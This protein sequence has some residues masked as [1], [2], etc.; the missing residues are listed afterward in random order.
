LGETALIDSAST[1]QI[2]CMADRTKGRV[3]ISYSHQDEHWLHLLQTHIKPFVRDGTI[4]AWADT[5]ICPGAKWKEEILTALNSAEVAVLLVTPNFLASDFIA[6][7]ELR[8]LSQSAERGG[9]IILWVAVS[10][11]SYGVTEIA[12]YRAANDPLRPLD[13]L[14]PAELNKSLVRIAENIVA[15][16]SDSLKNLTSGSPA[17]DRSG[18]RSVTHRQAVPNWLNV[19]S[20]M[21]LSICVVVASMLTIATGVVFRL[22]RAEARLGPDSYPVVWIGWLTAVYLFRWIGSGRSRRVRR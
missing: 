11:S 7:H 13:S 2:V 6:Q 16:S 18:R 10:A 19:S 9:V 8:P 5:Q 1:Q 15:A 22:W 4:D 3:F 20:I 17:S 12:E 21:A 14:N